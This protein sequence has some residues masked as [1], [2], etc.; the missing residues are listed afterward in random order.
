[1]ADLLGTSSNPRFPE[2]DKW[3]N[4][5]GGLQKKGRNFS[6]ADGWVLT[7]SFNFQWIFQ[8]LLIQI[9]IVCVCILLHL[10]HLHCLPTIGPAA[11]ELVAAALA[12]RTRHG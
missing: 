1:M 5:L 2:T 4:R 3:Q 6:T 9:P 12:W 10:A 8:D 7:F 11:V